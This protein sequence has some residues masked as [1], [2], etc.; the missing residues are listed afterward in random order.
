MK[1][2]YTLSIHFTATFDGDGCFVELE[3]N[4]LIPGA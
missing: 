1:F 2:P 4:D 3:P